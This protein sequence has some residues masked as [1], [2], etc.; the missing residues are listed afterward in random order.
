M[1]PPC[2]HQRAALSD[3][4]G[5]LARLV[6]VS[7]PERGTVFEIDAAGGAVGRGDGARVKLADPAV[8]R[9]NIFDR[10]AVNAMERWRYTATGQQVES[11]RVFDFKLSE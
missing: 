11:S 6:A 10:E 2:G 8:S 3:T 1:L 9:N 7:G 4:G 5:V